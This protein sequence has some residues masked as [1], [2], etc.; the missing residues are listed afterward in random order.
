MIRNWIPVCIG[1]ALCVL[2]FM[3]MG[4]P[5]L[6]RRRRFVFPAFFAAYFLLH[7]LHANVWH[8]GQMIHFSCLILLLSLAVRLWSEADWAACV[9]IALLFTILGNCI[10]PLRQLLLES[11]FPD[12]EPWVR[13]LS[14]LLFWL[15][16]CILVCAL[17]FML[18]SLRL[19]RLN[20][21]TLALLALAV[22]PFFFFRLAGDRR[23]Y[24]A[25]L[26]L[27]V[28]MCI[29]SLLLV[30]V[31]AWNIGYSSKQAEKL[32]QERVHFALNQQRNQFRK[33]L[34][35]A[36]TVNIKYHDL[37]NILLYL[38]NQKGEA[39]ASQEAGRLAEEISS[40]EN[41][42]DTGNE[43]LSILLGKKLGECAQKKIS[44]TPYVDGRLLSFVQPIDLCVIFGNALDNAIESC[45]KIPD[46]ER[47]Q[48]SIKAARKGNSVFLVF[49]NTFEKTPCLDPEEELPLSS[50]GDR[51]NHGY[52][53]RSIRFL[54]N[55][56]HGT[57]RCS[58]EQDEFILQI[59]LIE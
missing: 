11:F 19:I 2:L 39:W 3:L 52:G 23:Y 28:F 51:E 1:E 4:D 33:E 44:C 20:V 43:A 10:W 41:H 35:D 37:K 30:L 31:I 59:V 8:F 32:A 27:Q 42:V 22:F 14:I 21:P 6:Q 18:P 5:A 36:E 12:D 45:E 48:I 55:K 49:R 13:A 53:L 38:E 17:R 57:L 15:L 50:K 26:Q 40:Y 29:Y 46:P 24:D 16:E 54:A 9:I 47:R 58:V 34:K 56:Y 25:N 7:Y